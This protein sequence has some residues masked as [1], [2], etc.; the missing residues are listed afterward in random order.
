M[1]DLVVK[2]AKKQ[3]KTVIKDLEAL[4]EVD[5]SDEDIEQGLVSVARRTQSASAGKASEKQSPK[6]RLKKSATNVP[7]KAPK[8]RKKKVP[9]LTAS[10]MS[11]LGEDD[12]DD[13]DIERGLIV[14]SIKS[15]LEATRRETAALSP[16]PEPPPI[17]PSKKAADMSLI[18]LTDSEHEDIMPAN[19]DEDYDPPTFDRNMDDAPQADQNMSWLRSMTMTMTGATF[20]IVDSSPPPVPKRTSQVIFERMQLDDESMEISNPDRLDDEVIPTSDPFEPMAEDS[21]E[22]VE[23]ELPPTRTE[24]SS[25]QTTFSTTF[26]PSS[27]LHSPL[28]SLKANKPKPSASRSASSCKPPSSPGRITPTSTANQGAGE[29]KKGYV[30]P[31]PYRRGSS[32]RPETPRT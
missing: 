5:G 7:K 6:S 11:A 14:P 16:T 10:Q 21:V 3:K 29:R 8:P 2:G 15:Q 25:S 17:E 9:K 27:A 32:S 31:G 13:R 1:R 26:R 12:S 18:E 22:F 23:P 19:R 28:R 20:E 30:A 4:A 24:K